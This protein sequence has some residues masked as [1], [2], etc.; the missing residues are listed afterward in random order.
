MDPLQCKNKIIETLHKTKKTK[1]KLTHK[2]DISNHQCKKLLHYSTQKF[3]KRSL[4]PAQ[5]QGS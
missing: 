5:Y 1:K 3:G 4:D 2:S